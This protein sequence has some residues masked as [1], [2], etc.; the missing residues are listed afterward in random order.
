MKNP[1]SLCA[2]ALSLAL[3]TSATAVRAQTPPA[4]Q[5]PS[6]WSDEYAKGPWEMST[7]KDPADG[8]ILWFN[9]KD[10]FNPAPPP[11]TMSNIWTAVRISASMHL[12]TP[13]PV[14]GPANIGWK[15]WAWAPLYRLELKTHVPIP[16][17]Q[18]GGEVM[19]YDSWLTPYRWQV[20]GKGG[21]KVFDASKANAEVGTASQE[22]TASNPYTRTIVNQPTS[23]PAPVHKKP[24]HKE[25][26]KP[27]AEQPAVVQ[28]P[29]E[30]TPT[31]PAD[32]NPPKAPDQAVQPPAQTPAP[33]A[34]ATQKLSGDDINRLKKDQLDAYAK[35]WDAA[36][37]DAEKNAVNKKYKDL[38]E[39]SS[40]SA[41][42]QGA[43][44]DKERKEYVKRWA[45]AKT[46]DAKRAVNKEFMV[47]VAAA[48]KAEENRKAPP[49]TDKE[50][51]LL[52]PQ[53]KAAYDQEMKAAGTDKAKQG[54]VSLKYRKTLARRNIDAFNNLT[55]AQKK[56]V[57]DLD[58]NTVASGMVSVATGA[59]D[60]AQMTQDIISAKCKGDAEC[61]KNFKC[62]VTAPQTAAPP[63]AVPSD[64]KITDP[65]GKVQSA[66]AGL[67]PED[68]EGDHK[69]RSAVTKDSK[70]KL[71][72][73]PCPK[74]TQV[75]GKPGDPA[76]GD[77][78]AKENPCGEKKAFDDR[79]SNNL[80]N[81]MPFALSALV[82]GS[83]FGGPLVMA[84]FAVAAGVGAYLLSKKIGAPPKKDD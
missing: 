70:A 13:W 12:G 75:A 36:K 40:L 39:A 79:W 65:T 48:R 9:S 72:K 77:D 42:E 37:T 68:T 15:Q 64:S 31:K 30:T 25:P 50:I 54:A 73:N 47:K 8:A 35:D 16:G 46:D 43:L 81:A 5:Q 38:N 7:F 59:C 21:G 80:A 45:A 22:N 67:L 83:F 78:G 17:N 24:G 82:L 61:M 6:S 69:G 34:S 71:D 26:E 63:A 2:A 49:L 32:Q 53:E 51:A 44:T 52:T 60:P 18:H 1:S 14:P 11:G 28:K 66:C 4:A 19:T 27:A 56:D 33:A 57:C 84:A 41:D 76:A 74:A 3:A 20:D 10:A 62:D 29:A 23:A 58:K 55:H